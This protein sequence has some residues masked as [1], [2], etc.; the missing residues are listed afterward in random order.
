MKN[1]M[2]AVVLTKGQALDLLTAVETNTD[3]D[4]DDIEQVLIDVVYPNKYACPSCGVDA[5]DVVHGYGAE[6]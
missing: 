5:V 6:G 4:L 3:L 1:N 2:I